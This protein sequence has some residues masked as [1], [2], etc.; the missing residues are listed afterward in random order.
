[1]SDFTAIIF[2]TILTAF[3]CFGF[4]W[5]LFIRPRTTSFKRRETR[6]IQKE[7]DKYLSERYD[8]AQLK[9]L[10]MQF[11]SSADQIFIQVLLPFF[12]E[13][14][15]TYRGAKV[16]TI[17]PSTWDN[18]SYSIS[19]D[20]DGRL[21]KHAYPNMGLDCKGVWMAAVKLAPKYGIEGN[22]GSEY[23]DSP[24]FYF[25]KKVAWYFM[26]RRSP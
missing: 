10:D 13:M 25:E 11:R 23:Y 16:I 24:E 21:Y 1:M 4:V 3:V 15:R 22:L 14:R 20:L 7:W 2:A 8:S 17:S 26:R 19:C 5:W 6:K 12:E 9:E 18:Y